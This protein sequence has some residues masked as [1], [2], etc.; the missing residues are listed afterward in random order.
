M[1][2]TCEKRLEAKMIWLRTN[3]TRSQMMHV[4]SA[5]ELTHVLP[6]LLIW[7]PV[8]CVCEESNKT[9]N[10]A[11]TIGILVVGHTLCSLRLST[12]VWD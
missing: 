2:L 3:L 4:P 8:T 7:I 6:L 11:Q 1:I 5:L 12:S 9:I 10:T